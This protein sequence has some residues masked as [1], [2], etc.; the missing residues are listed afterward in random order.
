ML[1]QPEADDYVVATGESHS[2]REFA[3]ATFAHF[4]LDWKEHV[5]MDPRY[6]R[7]SEVDHLLGDSSK[8]RTKLG[9]APKVS[10]AEL[11]RMMCD[12]DLELAKQEKTLRDAGHTQGVSRHSHE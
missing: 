3:Q 9:W 5:E 4:G 8:A 1:Q 2:V 7:P 12:A 11:V 10:F 6:L